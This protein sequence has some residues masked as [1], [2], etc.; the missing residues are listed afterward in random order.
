MSSKLKPKK[1]SVPF[2]AIPEFHCPECQYQM[3]VT[4][5]DSLRIT[6][7]EAHA[8]GCSRPNQELTRP[9]AQFTIWI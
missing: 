1:G 7:L 5:K 3:A 6:I 8:P 2:V 4:Y 9:I